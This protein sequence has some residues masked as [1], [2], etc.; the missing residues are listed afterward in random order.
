MR[1][2]ILL[3]SINGA[4]D[5][6]RTSDQRLRKPLLYPTELQVQGKARD[7]TDLTHARPPAERINFPLAPLC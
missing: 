4:P 6:I 2:V 5:W 3:T 7:F 1:A